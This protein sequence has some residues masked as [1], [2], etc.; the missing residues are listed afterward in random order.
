LH[1]LAV[2]FQV[3]YL[4]IVWY[5][6]VLCFGHTKNFV[7]AV[8][9]FHFNAGSLLKLCQNCYMMS[10]TSGPNFPVGFQ[11]FPYYSLPLTQPSVKGWNIWCSTIHYYY[12]TKVCFCQVLVKC[13]AC[14]WLFSVILNMY[15]ES[16]G[17]INVC[18]DHAGIREN[19]YFSYYSDEINS[20]LI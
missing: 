12:F 10:G 18:N 16:E 8:E 17:L 7:H 9:Q 4:H 11:Y 5:K 2:W 13:V 19:M 15:F 3:Q 1:L 20:F 14:L 6:V